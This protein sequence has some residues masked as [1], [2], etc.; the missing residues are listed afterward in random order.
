MNKLS[1]EKRDKIILVA[2][3]TIIAIVALWLL[4]INPLRAKTVK[5]ANEVQESRDRVQRGERTMA[6]SQQVALESQATSNKLASA[7]GAMAGGDLYAWMISTMNQFKQAHKV[8]IP[9]ISRETL[10]EVGALP[11]FPYKAA[12]FLVRGTGYY[13]DFG[14]FLADFENQFPHMRVQNVEMEPQSVTKGEKNENPEQISFKI[15]IV[16]LIKPVAL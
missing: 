11:R 3:G 8:E 7:E 5:L 14:K 6:T 10:C 12:S 16:T 2:G 9:L 1:K 4:L 15:E 13:H